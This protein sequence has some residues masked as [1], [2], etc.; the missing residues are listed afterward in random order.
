MACTQMILHF[1]RR[2]QEEL[3]SQTAEAAVRLHFHSDLKT[4]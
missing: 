2:H 3:A 1:E 4:L